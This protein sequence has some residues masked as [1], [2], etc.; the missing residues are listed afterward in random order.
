MVPEHT[1]F[2]NLYLV[3]DLLELACRD[4]LSFTLLPLDQGTHRHSVGVHLWSPLC[5]GAVCVC[6]VLGQAQLK[7]GEPHLL[8]TGSASW[9]PAIW[10]ALHYCLQALPLPP[11]QGSDRTGAQGADHKSSLLGVCQ[12]NAGPQPPSAGAGLPIHLVTWLLFLGQMGQ[13][14]WPDGGWWVSG[15][16]I[17]TTLHGIW[18][19]IK[20]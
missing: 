13:D 5:A 3:W 15:G 1:I 2:N 6:R 14:H 20:L 17:P 19:L 7:T 8:Q 10:I 9:L 18:Y 12:W 11:V 16:L 4:S